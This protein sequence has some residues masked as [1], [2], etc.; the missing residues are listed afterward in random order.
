PRLVAAATLESLR[1]NVDFAR[2]MA[3]EPFRTD[4]AW[5]SELHTVRH[6][7]IGQYRDALRVATRDAGSRDDQ[8]AQ[9]TE[10]A[11]TAFL[12]AIADACL[13]W[14]LF[15]KEQ[16]VERVLDQIMRVHA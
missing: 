11:G 4:R 1:S 10:N 7:H 8:L 3:S 2:I 12:G 14:L 13:D 9:I 15:R 6:R 16:P 5:Y